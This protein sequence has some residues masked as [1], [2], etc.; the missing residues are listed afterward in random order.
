MTANTIIPGD[1]LT[2]LQ[3][4][5]DSCVDCCVTSPP[6][7]GLRDYGT[8]TW[9]GGDSSCNH[10]VVR[11]KGYD[12]TKQATNRGQGRP[13][14][15]ACKR[16]GAIRVDRQLGLEDTPELYIERLAAV[17]MEVHRVMK[18]T[19]TLWINI[20]DSYWGGKGYSGSS[21]GRYQWDRH[22]N[23]KSMTAGYSN[24]GGKGIIRPTD[25]KHEYIKNKDMTGVP[26]ILALT[27]RNAGWYLRNGNIWV[28]PN[29]MP[30]S[31]IDRFS[32]AHEYVLLLA[33]SEKYYF[34]HEAVREPAA[35]D[36]RKDTVMKGSKKYS[37][38]STE[39]LQ[40]TF[41]ARAHERWPHKTRGYATKEGETG[42]FPSHHG[43]SIPTYPLR[44]KRDVWVVNTKS[45]PEAHFATYPQELIVPCIKA[46]C[47]EN[48]I[49]LDPF[50]GAGTTAIV[51]RKLNRNY[52]G[53]E[54]NPKYVALAERRIRSELGLFL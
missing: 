33:K 53:V 46:G 47:P 3:T 1:A 34:D 25:K 43:G 52:L 39:L 48:G 20:G 35:Y 42:L 49:V 7:Y 50:M 41:A 16:C 40:Q 18:P 54:L 29:P 5:P 8:A 9:E 32:N 27:L 26:W 36:G 45:Y 28:K 38:G 11:E 10:E 2:V 22:N 21:A 30:E 24:I 14:K 31:V 12:R 51:A 19:G 37:E 23:G 44:N 13:H 6:Y 15:G 4:L 17:F